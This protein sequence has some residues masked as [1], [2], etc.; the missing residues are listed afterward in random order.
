MPTL[1]A[2]PAALL[3]VTV[4]SCTPAVPPPTDE[5]VSWELA[6]HRRTTLGDVAY[7]VQLRIPAARSQAV[8][9]TTTVSFRWD[10]PS[11]RA[12]VLDFK[13]PGARVDSVWSNG[14]PAV[15]EAVNDHVVVGPEGLR[16]GEE[17]VVR[18][19]FL[20]DAES[21][22][23]AALE[24]FGGHG[25][26]GAQAKPAAATPAQVHTT[27][28]TVEAV[29]QKAG[30]VEINHEAIPSLKWP[31]MSMEFKVKDKAMLQGVRKGQA[32]EIDIAPAGP[33]EFVIERMTP[34]AAKPVAKAAPGHD[35]GH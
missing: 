29:D 20:I 25:A 15:W 6:E 8:Q 3:A 4:L 23:K 33:G 19:N 10:D 24:T 7:D 12:L 16:A 18:A 32:V 28:G 11:R 9:G 14:E 34:A 30:S 5:G 31:A 17:V 21:N 13:D 2:A 22:L 27:K 35:K 26:H 1:R